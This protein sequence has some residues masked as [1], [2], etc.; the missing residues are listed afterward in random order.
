MLGDAY[1]NKYNKAILISGDGDFTPLVERVKRLKKEID[2]CYFSE[3][4]SESLLNAADN[5]HLI[6]K[7]IVKK[8]FYVTKTKKQTK[9]E[10]HTAQ[11]A[12]QMWTSQK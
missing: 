2:V 9:Q 1:E 11:K 6:N 12:M 4:V 3:C 5:G 8:F 7:K 10:K